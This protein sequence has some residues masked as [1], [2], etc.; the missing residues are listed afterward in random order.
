MKTPY[1]F[2]SPFCKWIWWNFLR[3]LKPNFK[4]VAL[5]VYWLILLLG[6]ILIFFSCDRQGQITRVIDGDTFVFN[7]H[8]KIRMLNIDAPELSQPFGQ[9]SKEFLKQYE[10]KRCT[11]KTQGKDKYGRTLAVLYVDN[12][13]INL[14]SVNRGL[15]WKFMSH[16]ENYQQ[17]QTYAQDHKLGLWANDVIEPYQWRKQHEKR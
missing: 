1:K 11:I 3:R 2:K 13:N 4:T 8:T 15:A 6:F 12:Q 16:D 9:E 10:G 14:L 7:Y 17:A 5:I